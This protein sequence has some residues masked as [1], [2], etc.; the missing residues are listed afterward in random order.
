MSTHTLKLP[1][2]LETELDSLVNATGLS[3][4]YFL[5]EA[6]QS[7]VRDRKSYIKSASVM[8]KIASGEL[9]VKSL[10]SVMATHDLVG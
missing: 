2:S 10:N 8:E 7:Y 3:K 6:F 9:R 5:I 4:S 1:E